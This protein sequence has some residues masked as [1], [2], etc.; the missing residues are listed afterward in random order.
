MAFEDLRENLA[1]QLRYRLSSIKESSIFMTLRRNT[2]FSSKHTKGLKISVC[3]SA[4]FLF[5]LFPIP[6]LAQPGNSK[7]TLIQKV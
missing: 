3:A 2:R 6:I 4:F 7:K 5:Q 1:E